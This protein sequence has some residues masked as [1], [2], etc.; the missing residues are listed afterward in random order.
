MVVRIER[1]RTL[2]ER[3]AHA[4]RPGW[5]E[6]PEAPDLLRWWDGAHWSDDAFRP[7]PLGDQRG[8]PFAERAR[9]MF[10]WALG[11]VLLFWILPIALT[12]VP[13]NEMQTLGVILVWAGA[14]PGLVLIVLAVV[15]GAIGLSRARQAEGQGRTSALTGLIGGI[16][17]FLAPAVLGIIGI[18][19]AVVLTNV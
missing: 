10:F 1:T 9:T 13:S 8:N 17:L 11:V 5:Y 2:T 15:F 14:L 19:A 3:I 6:D 12:F 18:A 7:K 4:A 16:S